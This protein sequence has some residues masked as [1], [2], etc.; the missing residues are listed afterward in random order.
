MSAWS[1]DPQGVLG[2]L[3]QVR[4]ESDELVKAFD[5]VATAQEDLLGGVTGLPGVAEAVASVLASET[6]RFTNVGNR[7]TA[8]VLGAGSATASYNNADE[9]M[10]GT[11]QRAAL[12]AAVSG[13]FAYFTA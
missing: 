12:D 9:Q 10:A 2:I 8:G 3:T 5:T 7:I 13:D 4:L 6:A 11:A 1:I